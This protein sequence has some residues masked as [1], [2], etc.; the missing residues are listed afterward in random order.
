MPPASGGRGEGPGERETD[1]V[2]TDPVTTQN[3]VYVGTERLP[4]SEYSP[5]V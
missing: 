3:P 1:V 2:S 4:L 5:F